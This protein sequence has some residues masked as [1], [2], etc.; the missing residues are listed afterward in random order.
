[1]NKEML[2]SVII[3]TLGRETLYP[4]VEKLLEQKTKFNYE[5]VIVPQVKLKE[6]LLR[7]KRIKIF[8]EPLGKGFAYYRNIGIKKSG[9]EII[10]FIDDDEMPIGNKWLNNLVKPIL[11]NNEKVVTSGYKIKLGEEYLTDSI[12]LLG[13]PGGGA[14]GF[15]NMWGVNSEDY[16]EHICTGNMSIKKEVISKLGGFDISLKFGNEDVDLGDRLIFNNI[17]IKYIEEAT[18]YHAPRRGFI[19]FAKWNFLRG[20][21]AAEYLSK[22]RGKNK[23]YHRFNS[24]LI[25]INKNYKS[26]LILGILFM[27]FFQYVFQ[28]LGYI[29]QRITNNE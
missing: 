18:V 26:I 7:N 1:M 27:M 19:N 14:I 22:R 12:S 28:L 17:K 15:R 23:I 25:I 4:L 8:Y 20:R 16:T 2:V 9:G 10:S 11:E 29:N 21:S 24:S 13:F 6:N 5:I 3:P